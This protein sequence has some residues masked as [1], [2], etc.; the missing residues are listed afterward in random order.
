METALQPT[1]QQNIRTKL[2]VI[3]AIEL[4][5]LTLAFCALL[6]GTTPSENGGDVAILFSFLVVI[7][8]GSWLIYLAYIRL[9]RFLPARSDIRLRFL[10][11]S[12]TGTYT[13]WAWILLDINRFIVSKLL[14]RG[15]APVEYA[16]SWRSKQ[17]RKLWEQARKEGSL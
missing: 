12:L 17:N 16:W 4:T 9:S 6:E 11:A 8:L 5:L 7:V 15:E 13:L 10:A 1:L 2:A 3:E 14:Y